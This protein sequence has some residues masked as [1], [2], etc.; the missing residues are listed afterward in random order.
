MEPNECN[1]FGWVVEVDPSDP[2]S[3]PVKHSAL[4]RFRHEGAECTLSADGHAV[5]YMGDDAR[6]DYL[7]RFVSAGTFS[8]DDR[9]AN[10]TLLSDG[11][12]YVARFD[13]D[14]TMDVAAARVRRRPA[15]TGE[16]I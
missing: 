4:G 16:R 3:T 2:G 9:A 7:Y 1:R 13:E 15:D 8:A 5:V 11:T 14:G 10:M 12:L 6:F